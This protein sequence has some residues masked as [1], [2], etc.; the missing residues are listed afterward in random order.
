MN[1]LDVLQD[2]EL[3]LNGDSI[4]RRFGQKNTQP[5]KSSGKETAV[6]TT[7]SGKTIYVG[8]RSGRYHYSSSGKKVYDRRR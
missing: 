1:S 6:E 7:P 2:E 4:H 3:Y 8:P 5:L